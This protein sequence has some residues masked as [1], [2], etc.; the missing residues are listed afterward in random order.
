MSDA[1]EPDVWL[2]RQGRVL[3]REL[4]VAGWT[5]PPRAAEAIVQDRV[6]HAVL[7][8][9]LAEDHVRD[10][11]TTEHVRAIAGAIAA[12]MWRTGPQASTDGPTARLHGPLGDDFRATG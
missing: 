10:L 2:R 4:A 3:L 8:S 12:Q 5:M 9:G 7:A 1:A 6:R 11:M